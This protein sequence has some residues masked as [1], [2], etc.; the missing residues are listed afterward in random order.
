MSVQ[1]RRAFPVR[2]APVVRS[3]AEHA[4]SKAKAAAQQQKPSPP[5]RRPG[6]PQGSRSKPHAAVPLTPELSRITA[7][8]DAVLKLIA[9]VIPL[10]SLVL[11]GHCGHHNARQMARHSRLHLISKA[12]VRC[13]VAL[14][15]RRPLG[16]AGAPS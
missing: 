6:R 15:L 16:W 5:W 10:T 8:L 3:D 12:A 1:A 11:D 7:R 4:A 2:V 9:G 13:G 14:P